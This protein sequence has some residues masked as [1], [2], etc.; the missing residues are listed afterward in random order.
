[1][2]QKNW[3]ENLNWEEVPMWKALKLWA[4]ECRH[5]KC[6]IGKSNY[7]YRGSEIID[8][9]DSEHVTEGVWFAEIK[10]G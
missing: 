1:M 9:L 10:E 4:E 3:Y 5:I 8:K 7:F 6:Q 2:K